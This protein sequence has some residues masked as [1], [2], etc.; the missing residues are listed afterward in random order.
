[1]QQQ[2]FSYR[3]KLCL[4]VQINLFKILIKSLN[5]FRYLDHVHYTLD[6]HETSI[7]LELD[8]E[9]IKEKNKHHQWDVI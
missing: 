1:M 7:D 5:F 3:S 4:K 8:K 9:K 2:K 6:K